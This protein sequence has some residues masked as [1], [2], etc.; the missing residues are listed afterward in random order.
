MEVDALCEEWRLKE[1]EL[2]ALKDKLLEFDE[3]EAIFAS[4]S[5]SSMSSDLSDFAPPEP[6]TPCWLLAKSVERS[7]S[8]STFSKDRKCGCPGEFCHPINDSFFST[9]GR[10]EQL[11]GLF[12]EN[13]STVAV[14]PFSY[15]PDLSNSSRVE[16]V[17]VS[18]DTMA[19]SLSST[20]ELGLK[21][22]YPVLMAPTA[23]SYYLGKS[24]QKHTTLRTIVEE[25]ESDFDKEFSQPFLSPAPLSLIP[26]EP[27]ECFVVKES[28][29]TV[30]PF[31]FLQPS[32]LTREEQPVSAQADVKQ[33]ASTQVNVEQPASS[34]AFSQA[35]VR[36]PARKECQCTW[37][38]SAR[39]EK[40]TKKVTS[41]RCN[42]TW[43]IRARTE[44]IETK[45]VTSKKC[46]CTWCIRA[47]TEKIEAKKV[48]SKKCNCTWC[49]RART[50]KIEAKMV[51]SKKCYCTW[52][53]RARTEKIEA[54]KVTSKKCNCTWCIR[55]RT[56]KIE[57]KMVT[58]KKCNC[59]WCIRARTE[60]ETKK[61]TS[62]KEYKA[63]TA[64][65][66]SKVV[67]QETS[68]H[69]SIE[70]S[71]SS[72]ANVQQLA[73]TTANIEQL[74][75]AQANVRQ[76][77]RKDCNCTW[78]IRTRTEKVETKKDMSRKEYRA[79]TDLEKSK[80]TSSVETSDEMLNSVL[81]T[82]K[83]SLPSRYRPTKLIWNVLSSGPETGERS[84]GIDRKDFTFQLQLSPTCTVVRT[85]S[86]GGADRAVSLGR[87]V[88]T[89]TSHSSLMPP[90]QRGPGC[91][92]G[93]KE[94]TRNKENKQVK[95]NCS[96]TY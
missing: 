84:R 1:L 12:V 54:K 5:T 60:K 29:V 93:R 26:R 76:P 75:S 3:G 55:V 82:K 15:C 51:T 46:N 79:R 91:R 56:E 81:S 40:E 66:K 67:E 43:C 68:S 87:R 34:E 19:S 49:I 63:K 44:K 86:H 92:Q 94:P 71:A 36:K 69:T 37:H 28:T 59:T 2:T 31:A 10:L 85:A 33:P 48:T 13:E 16:S 47:R 96:S 80:E 21:S 73:S 62:K 57:T 18:T 35:N 30:S 17:C 6:T 90:S 41:K 61:V 27:R 53:I 4:A 77:A 72:Q 45:K 38:I 20:A 14:S 95:R 52:C 58:S 9:P 39:S 83:P 22:K 7:S 74:V 42:C 50:E 88:D 23:P 8:L 89:P 11:S 78:C 64:L 70:H 24:V 65:E 25:E 32:G